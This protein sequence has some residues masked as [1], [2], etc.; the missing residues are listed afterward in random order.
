MEGVSVLALVPARGGSKGIAGKNVR[1][2]LGRPLIEWS[3][4]A[5]RASGIF[6]RTVVSTDDEETASIARAA[7]A[8]VPFV[9]PQE[10]AGD[11]TP[12]APVVRHALDWLRENDGWS[13]DVVFVLEPTAPG[14]TAADLTGALDL[15]LSAGADS[16]ASVSRV[17]HHF[18]PSKQLELRADGTIAGADGA[19]V[20]AMIHR[21]QE[22][23]PAY[24]FDGI[25]FGCRTDLL[26][27]DPPTL[28]GETVVGYVVDAARAVDLDREEDWAPA[29]ARLRETLA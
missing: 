25:V 7:G 26:L 19:A 10:L 11:E 3:L 24:A 15:L 21:R 18:V 29:E 2:F 23:A 16:V 27:A 12:T 14:R 20:G 22:L 28:W 8:D 13:P 1:P 6:D 17:P 5:A 4:D 9:R